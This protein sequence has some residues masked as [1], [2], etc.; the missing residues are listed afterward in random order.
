[1]HVPRIVTNYIFIV[2]DIYI[3]VVRNYNYFQTTATFLYGTRLTISYTIFL[4]V[5]AQ[6]HA[7]IHFI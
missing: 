1:M 3:E 4:I 6:T 5:L 2:W 7:K